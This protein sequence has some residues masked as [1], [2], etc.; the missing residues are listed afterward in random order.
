MVIELFLLVTSLV[1]FWMAL[2]RPSGLP[3]GR[4][5]LPVIGYVPTGGKYIDDVLK[6]FQKEFGDIY[7]WK[8][9]SRLQVYIHDYQLVKQAF[10]SPD[11]VGR[12]DMEVFRAYEDDTYG[13][14]G[15]SGGIWHTN[16]RF[17]LRQLRDLGMGKSLLAEAVQEQA[18]IL[19]E[20]LKEQ[21]GKAQ[22]VAEALNFVIMNII[23][24]MTANKHFEMSSPKHRYLRQL[25]A[26][27]TPATNKVAI[28]DMMPWTRT[29]LPAF[30]FRHIFGEDK[31]IEILNKFNE[32]FLEMIQ[33]HKES[34]N[35]D[36]PKDLIDHY[37]LEMNDREENPAEAEGVRNE[38]DLRILLFD[39]LFA[40][41]DTT[42]NTMKW[43]F[44]YMAAHPDKQRKL[45]EELDSAL[46]SG[47]LVTLEDKPRIP[48]TEAVINEILRMSSLANIG[49]PHSPTR[50]VV[51]AG[52][53]IPKGSL[54][55]PAIASM[56]YDPRY[57]DQPDL[58]LPE[59]WLS[60]EGKFVMRKEGYLP[61]GTGKRSCVGESLA[62]T[63]LLVFSTA[64]FQ[65]F[66]ISPPEGKNVDLLPDFDNRV[67]HLPRKQ[68]VVFTSRNIYNL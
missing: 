48:Y 56:H 44:L 24:K 7:I 68:D 26:E 27:S 2:K 4:W 18:K 45:Q 12:P 14:A 6:D 41:S 19:V 35:P 25:I 66:T 53:K 29:L 39:V 15:S 46:P 37:L 67:F 49:L 21:E 23:W 13:I 58:F 65:N 8:F 55:S 43:I 3:P 1:L 33:E 40:G 9:G 10:G 54:V 11:Y 60:P 17:I 47:T 34:L 51:L 32:F 59:R 57:W 16:R 30:I 36:D 38:A 63:E 42:Y 22:P 52:Y 31:F 64:V 61:F 50:D 28:A 62:R 20:A 5:G